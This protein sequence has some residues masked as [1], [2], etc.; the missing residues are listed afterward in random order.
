MESTM[1]VRG[2]ANHGYLGLIGIANLIY[3]TTFR[4][5]CLLGCDVKLSSKF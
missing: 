3:Q 1:F 2:T 4:E 5:S